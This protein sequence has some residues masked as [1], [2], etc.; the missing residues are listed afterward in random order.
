MYI[1]LALRLEKP[2]HE[3]N[4]FLKLPGMLHRTIWYRYIL[5]RLA[6]ALVV[7]SWVRAVRPSRVYYKWPV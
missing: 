1:R 3:R 4:L 5:R 2:Q 6:L 7:V